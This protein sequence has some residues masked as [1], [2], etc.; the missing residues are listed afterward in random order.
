M[1]SMQGVRVQSLDGELRSHMPHCVAKNN[2]KSLKKKSGFWSQVA[3]F[4]I[5]ASINPQDKGLNLSGL[6]F[7]ASTTG[8]KITSTSQSFCESGKVGV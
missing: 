1:L 3:W 7:P 2:I 6:H 4:Q 8:I 5:Q